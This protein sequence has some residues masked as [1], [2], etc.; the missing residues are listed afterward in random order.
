MNASNLI[1][2]DEY[3]R[4]FH[5]ATYTVDSAGEDLGRNDFVW[6]AFK[7]Q[8]A[9]EYAVKALLRALGLPSFGNSILIL[10]K[11]LA[12]AGFEVTEEIYAAARDLDH[13]YIPPRY[14]D[15]FPAGSPF[16]FYD[17]KTAE[18]AYEAAKLLISYVREQKE[19]L[20][21]DAQSSSKKAPKT[22]KA[23]LNRPNLC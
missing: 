16:D 6:S 11:E 22:K 17:R 8:Q 21:A 7:S 4:W 9:G 12:K 1:D 15:A 13:H 3:L 5:Q 18:A 2:G 14:P 20:V 23:D 10:L 19:V